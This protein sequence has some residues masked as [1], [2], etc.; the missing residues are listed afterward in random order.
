MLRNLPA[1]SFFLGLGSWYISHSTGGEPQESLTDEANVFVFCG[2][3]R[4]METWG[5]G[6]AGKRSKKFKVNECGVA[7][8]V[9]PCVLCES[10][11]RMRPSTIDKGG[12]T[13]IDGCDSAHTF[14]GLATA[15]SARPKSRAP[16]HKGGAEQCDGVENK[17][18]DMM[19][20]VGGQGGV[21]TLSIGPLVVLAR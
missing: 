9:R 11:A 20:S 18:R 1:R 10:D 8:R 13:K 15:E 19:L 21:A 16:R 17:R 3:L 12:F 7:M 2:V 5:R 14:R 6:G 4:Q